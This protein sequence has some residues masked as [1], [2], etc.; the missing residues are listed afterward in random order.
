MEMTVA[1]LAETLGKLPSDAAICLVMA[2]GTPAE[3]E[4]FMRISDSS[5]PPKVIIGIHG[6]KQDGQFNQE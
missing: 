4:G 5:V 2:D 1:K 3:I 6:L